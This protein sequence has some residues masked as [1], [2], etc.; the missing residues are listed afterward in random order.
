MVDTCEKEKLRGVGEPDIRIASS[1]EWMSPFTYGF[2][3]VFG[4]F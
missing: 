4:G 1:R 3:K 2:G